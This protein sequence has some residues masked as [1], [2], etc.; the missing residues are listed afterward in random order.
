MKTYEKN[1]LWGDS[2]KKPSSAFFLAMYV[3]LGFEIL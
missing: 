3:T 2:T 1:C